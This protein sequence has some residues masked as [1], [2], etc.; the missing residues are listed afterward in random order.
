MNFV[1]DATEVGAEPKADICQCSNCGWKG[2]TA[3]CETSLESDGWEYPEYRIHLCPKCADGGC[4]DQYYYSDEVM[5]L[6]K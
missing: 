1:L 5:G 3:D 4:I 6:I 2:P